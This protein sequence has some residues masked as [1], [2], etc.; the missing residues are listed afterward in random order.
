MNEK[1]LIEPNGHLR[2]RFT[3]PDLQLPNQPAIRVYNEAPKRIALQVRNY[4]TI[5]NGRKKRNM[6]AHA[7]LNHED[8]KAI[9]HMLNEALLDM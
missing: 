3:Q 6:I 4:T 2:V 5:G 8:A 7:S 9:I 1:R